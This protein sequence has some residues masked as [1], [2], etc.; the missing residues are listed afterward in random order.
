MRTPEMQ[1]KWQERWDRIAAAVRHEE[2]K[3]RLPVIMQGHIPAARLVDPEIVPG[4]VL[5]RTD[6]FLEKAFEGYES[7]KDIDAL[8]ALSGYGKTSGLALMCKCKRPGIEIAA[9]EILQIDEHPYM[10]YDD[11]KRILN[12]GWGAYKG[13]YMKEKLGLSMQDF[14][15]GRPWLEKVTAMQEKYG[16][17]QFSGV[18]HPDGWDQLSA[19][20]GMN[21]FFRDLRKDPE[22][23]KAVLKE[24]CDADMPRYLDTL[25]QNAET[26]AS[27]ACMCQPAVRANC[28]FVSRETY[29]EFVF[30]YALKYGN[31]I[32][33]S[34]NVVHFHYDSK[35]DDFLDLYREFR[36]DTCIFDCDE[37][38]D[39]YRVKKELGDTMAI[40]GNISAA[41]LAIGSP[42]E[43]YNATVKQIHDIGPAGYIV[44]SSC[45]CPANCKP[46]NLR[47]L[48]AAARG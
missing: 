33:D 2:P 40:T 39:I 17:L 28:N 3:D 35:W 14:A 41:L 46:D 5:S 20:R 22:L 18:V 19:M 12:E 9:T 29:E 23:I 44:T 8:N 4:D 36:K 6:Y 38:T 45:T 13:W 27:I 21:H 42:D 16:Y 25:K 34:G 48:I 7:L 32:I 11:Y 43:V 47:A 26:K 1:Q 37:M 30:P 24:M 15:D 10:E 31:A